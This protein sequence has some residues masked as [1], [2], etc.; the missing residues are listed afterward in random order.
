VTF[1]QKASKGS[2]ALAAF[3]RKNK[4]G[5]R[6]AARALDVAHPTLIAWMEG[7]KRPQAHRRQAIERWTGGEVKADWW[8]LA[9]ERQDVKDVVPFEPESAPE[10]AKTG[11]G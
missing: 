8:I 3:V 5:P 4:I 7:W 11:T 9:E 1:V 10:S 2:K 6:P